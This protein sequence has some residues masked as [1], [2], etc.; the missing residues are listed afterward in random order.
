MPYLLLRAKE[1]VKGD[2]SSCCPIGARVQIPPVNSICKQL[3]QW[4]PLCPQARPLAQ[5]VESP[6]SGI[7]GLTVAIGHT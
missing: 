3:H 5:L 7:C 6:K 1:V 2:D 4:Y